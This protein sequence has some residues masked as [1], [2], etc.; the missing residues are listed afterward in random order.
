MFEC[1][2]N[3]IKIKHEF[4][5]PTNFAIPAKFNRIEHSKD[6]MI[7]LIHTLQSY[8]TYL[9]FVDFIKFTI[10]IMLDM[11]GMIFVYDCIV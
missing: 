1:L 8:H 5:H 6:F 11:C 10:F 7:C 3:F 4:K 9:V 2:L